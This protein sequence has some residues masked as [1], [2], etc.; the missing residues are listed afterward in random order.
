MA[1]GA[2]CRRLRLFSSRSSGYPVRFRRGSDQDVPRPNPGGKRMPSRL[3]SGLFAAFVVGLLL[4]P[5]PAEGQEAGAGADAPPPG[6]DVQARGPVH[7]AFGEPTTI[8]GAAGAVVGKAPPALI[9]EAPP[10]EKPSGDNVVWI[11]GYW[12]WEDE[13]RDYLW[14]SGFWRAVPPG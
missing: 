7:E 6:A 13:A 10:E 4:C 9:E 8:V 3:F 11:P 1:S 5:K 2:C 14:I 12:G